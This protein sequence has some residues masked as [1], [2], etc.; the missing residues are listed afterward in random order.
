[1]R[2]R[3]SELLLDFFFL[4]MAAAA[5]AIHAPAGPQW[6]ILPLNLALAGW[7]CLFA[8]AHPGR[9]FHLL[10]RVR[11]W[12]PLAALLVALREASWLSVVR[13]PGEVETTL[14]QWDRAVLLDSGLKQLLDG[15]APLV[16]GTLEAAY[17][18]AAVL[19]VAMVL[20]FYMAGERDRIDDAWSAVLLAA[21]SV[22]AIWPWIP[23]EP[24][25]LVFPGDLL[26]PETWLRR[27]TLGLVNYAGGRGGTFPSARIAV[28][29]AVSLALLRLLKRWRAAGWAGLALALLAALAGVYGRYQF[30]ADVVAGIV[31]AVLAWVAAFL[32][33]RPARLGREGREEMF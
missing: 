15:G 14:R 2:F 3:R 10:D 18:L 26:P 12:W 31:V 27:V 21:L 33:T 5:F 23:M 19:P 22:L 20:L 1:M 8:W 7:S 16:P 29:F 11:D 30:A 25:R 24:P 6:L 9:G 28:A 4:Y 32:L 13:T 17:L